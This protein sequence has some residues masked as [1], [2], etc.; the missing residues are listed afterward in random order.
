M[1]A[2]EQQLGPQTLPHNERQACTCCAAAGQRLPM[3]KGVLRIFSKLM[4]SM[5]CGGG[6]VSRDAQPQGALNASRQS[7]PVLRRQAAWA[8][9]AGAA[10]ACCSKSL[11]AATPRLRNRAEQQLVQQM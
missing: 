7:L 8:G 9:G 5:V 2:S 11:G 3:M 4:L 6:I 1:V 10:A